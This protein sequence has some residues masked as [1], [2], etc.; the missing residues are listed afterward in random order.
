MRCQ[1]LRRTRR[2]SEAPARLYLSV[3]SARV[4]LSMRFARVHLSMRFARLP[5]AL[6]ALLVGC[7]GS[8]PKPA[9]EPQEP[10]TS[11]VEERPSTEGVG[12]VKP[13]RRRDATVP[14]D[15]SLTEGDCDALGKQY[16]VAMRNDQ[17]V[18]LNPKLSAAQRTQ[19]EANI[20]KVV[21]K[22]ATQWSEGCVHSLA[23]KVV[24]RKSLTC[25]LDART[26]NDFKACI[27]DEGATGKR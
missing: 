5:V 27:G 16:G 6:A 22:M 2:S 14:D 7:G 21:T 4:H 19:A 1:T 20:D 26:V 3:R 12:A 18:G 10:V 17:L 15:Y 9:E 8:S 23:G 24:D 11:T 13:A 25:A